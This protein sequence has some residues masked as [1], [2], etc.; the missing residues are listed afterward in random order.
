MTK[1]SSSSPTHGSTAAALK[2]LEA[3][4]KVDQPIMLKAADV[5]VFE[6][7]P[8]SARPPPSAPALSPAR[9]TA[10]G[11]TVPTQWFVTVSDPVSVNLDASGTRGSY[12]FEIPLD[13]IQPPV[14]RKTLDELKSFRV[15]I[16]PPGTTRPFEV[17]VKEGRPFLRVEIPEAEVNGLAGSPVMISVS[18]LEHIALPGGAKAVLEVRLS[19]LE[20]DR[21]LPTLALELKNRAQA[22]EE[23]S[24]QESALSALEDGTSSWFAH[25]PLETAIADTEQRLRESLHRLDEVRARMR[26]L[27]EAA[28]PIWLARSMP[29]RFPEQAA[30]F[31][32]FGR[33]QEAKAELERQEA[34]LAQVSGVP[35]AEAE[36]RR[37]LDE[38]RSRSGTA[39]SEWS[40]WIGTALALFRRLEE[41]DPT[42]ADLWLFRLGEQVTREPAEPFIELARS[43]RSEQQLLSAKRA[44]L[45]KLRVQS[46]EALPGAI[47]HRKKSIANARAQLAEMDRRIEDM[48]SD[49]LRLVDSHATHY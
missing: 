48:K 23:I 32:A 5:D 1:I 19:T 8:M 6:P 49:R 47:A 22:A 16:P 30:A 24:R 29:A 38:A 21:T 10:D 27:L 4:P 17:S 40:Q 18:A 41:Q 7:S 33:L 45:D 9:F 46:A 25:R 42:L 13:A 39:Q 44:E 11:E 31:T 36:V 35:A 12:G 43:M 3:A 14:S 34:L 20:V 2:D 37:Q 15:S 26:P 28:D